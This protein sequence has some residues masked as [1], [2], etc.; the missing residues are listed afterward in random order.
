MHGEHR[1]QISQA[2]I[3]GNAFANTAELSDP[4]Y[5]LSPLNLPP[6]LYHLPDRRVM[7][8]NPGTVYV[9]ATDGFWACQEPVAPIL[10]WPGLLAPCHSA[11]AMCDALFDAM[12]TAPP[13]EL[14]PDNLTAIVIRPL[15]KAAKPPCP[16]GRHE[17]AQKKI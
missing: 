5:A 9:L 15:A 4:L 3:L 17:H 2:F 14:Y 7:E 6:Y 16:Y 11:V 12:I 10:R 8:L 1:S 13:P